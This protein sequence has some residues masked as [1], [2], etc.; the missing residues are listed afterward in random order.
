[1]DLS[2]IINAMKDKHSVSQE[3]LIRG[4]GSRGGECIRRIGGGVRGMVQG[5]IR[6]GR[7]D[8][9]VHAEEIANVNS[10]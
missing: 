8:R 7:R 4:S 9:R 5:L 2:T 1:M 6:Q 3:H 10:L